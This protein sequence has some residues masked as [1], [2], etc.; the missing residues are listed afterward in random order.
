MIDE[1]QSP[2]HFSVTASG[3]I[4][5]YACFCVVVLLNHQSDIARQQTFVAGKVLCYT[6]FV[7]WFVVKTVHLAV[8]DN[9]GET[10]DFHCPSHL[11]GPGAEYE[12]VE[13]DGGHDVDEE[14]ALEVVLC[15]ASRVADH[16]VVVVDIGGPEVDEDVHDEHDVHHQVHHVERVAGVAAGSPPLFLHLIEEEGGRVRREDGGVD[17]QQQ[18]DPVP[19]CFEGAIVKD[20]PFVDA[21][22]LK[23]VLW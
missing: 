18:D 13:G 22:G 17:D 6:M 12:Q 1:N 7:F 10:V 2:T 15:D 3:S 23:L 20:G 16:L 11:L 8:W 4:A 5:S 19:H 21:W 9:T 14:P